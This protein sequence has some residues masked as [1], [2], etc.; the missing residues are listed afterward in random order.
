MQPT[1]IVADRAGGTLTI[2]WDDEHLSVFS[3]AALRWACPCA[4]CAGEWGRPGRLAGLELLPP[5]ELSLVDVHLV[6]PYGI[7]PIWASGHASGIYSYDYLRS[8]CPCEQC[9]GKDERLRPG[10]P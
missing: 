1:E 7:T 6:G 8:I 4:V 5:D 3:L 10:K 9:S 2:G